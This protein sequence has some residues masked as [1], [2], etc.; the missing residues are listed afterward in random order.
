M[1]GSAYLLAVV[2]ALM[3]AVG[4]MLA[5]LSTHAGG[6]ELGRTAAEFLL[7]HAGALLGVAGLIASAGAHPARALTL[8][9]AVMALGALLFSGDLASRAFADAKL[10]PF[11]APIGGSLMILGW[12]GLAIALAVGALR[13]TA[14]RG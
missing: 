9:G 6:G 3:G 11:A 14:E 7:L 10:F 2:A 5:A 12:I 1:P 8:A 4:V 13:A